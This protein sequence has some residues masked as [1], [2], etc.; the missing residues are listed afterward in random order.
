MIPHVTHFD[1]TDITELENFRKEQN[2]EAEKRKLDVKITPVVFIM[3]AVASALEAF[4]R[5][6]SSISEDAQRLT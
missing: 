6:N 2:K 4:P 3:K 5:F 1:R